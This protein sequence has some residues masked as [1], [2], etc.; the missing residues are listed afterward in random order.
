[1]ASTSANGITLSYETA[2]DPANPPLLLV[3]GLGGQLTAW[4]SRFVAAVAERGFWVITY[5]NRD[6]G[7]STLFDEAGTP[8]LPGMI[9]GTAKPPYFLDDMAADAAGLLDALAVDSAHIVGMSMGGMIAQAFAI[10]YPARVRTLTSIM[11]TTGDPTVGQPHPEALDVLLAPPATN[12]DD[13]IEQSVKSWRVIGSPG[14]DF[15]EEY[16]R[17]MAAVSYDRAFHPEGTGRQL[18]AIIG[19][20]DRTPGLRAL[21]MPTLVIHGEEDPLVDVSGGKATA[22]AVPGAVLTLIPGMAHDLPPELFDELAD[23]IAAHAR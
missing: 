6:V 1:M 20:P 15:D 10:A 2:G 18:A 13:V 9:A 22:A 4:D 11:S 8:D 14:F 3:M 7:L 12:R 16:V 21:T 23:K 17:S 19:S 5:D